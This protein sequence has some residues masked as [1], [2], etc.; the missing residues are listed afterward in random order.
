MFL[1]TQNKQTSAPHRAPATGARNIPFSLVGSD[2]TITGNIEATVDLH[3][4][5][6]VDGDIR[7]AALV[8][9]PDSRIK[10]HVTA[11]SARIAGHVEGSISADELT[12]E[13]S[14]RITGDVTYATISIAT[15]GQVAGQFRHKNV[16]QG[17]AE[18]KQITSEA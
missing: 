11:K 17:H 14:A 2:I 7:C 9:G 15:G 18:L 3:I 16:P 6:R 12:V 10:G 5:G 8:Q 13:A 1:K 4:D